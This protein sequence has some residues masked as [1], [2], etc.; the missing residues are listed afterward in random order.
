MDISLRVVMHY[1]SFA[2]YRA[3]RMPPVLEAAAAGAAATCT[4]V[5]EPPPPPPPARGFK[6]VKH[7]P[8][9]AIKAPI[10]SVPHTA[11]TISNSVGSRPIAVAFAVDAAV[12][13]VLAV[14]WARQTCEP[15]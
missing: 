11:I 9:T 13:V 1:S 5:F 6:L 14:C 2:V 3:R 4:L 7:Q 10:N 15:V 12:C 8:P